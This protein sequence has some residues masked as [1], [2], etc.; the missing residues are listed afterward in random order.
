MRTVARTL[1]AALLS[2]QVVVVSSGLQRGRKQTPSTS[3]QSPAPPAIILG[4][5]P[6]AEIRE[7]MQDERRAQYNGE[8]QAQAMTDA[9][10]LAQLSK[11]LKDE[12]EHAG[13]DR[14]PA[15]LFEKTDEIIKLAKSVKG[16]MRSF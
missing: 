13:S 15:S 16:N 2:L 10:R 9:R 11:E 1:L 3:I 8:R 4:D 5:S 12:L 6:N 14:L 7:P